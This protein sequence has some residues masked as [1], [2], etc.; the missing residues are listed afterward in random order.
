MLKIFISFSHILISFKLTLHVYF[1][2]YLHVPQVALIFPSIP[3]ND[4]SHWMV[5]KNY[6]HIDGVSTP[7]NGVEPGRLHSFS[8]LVG[9]ALTNQQ[10]DYCGN[11]TVFP[12]SH[13]KVSEKLYDQ[14]N[15]QVINL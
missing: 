3:S 6:A 14:W 4:P 8:L 7:T 5:S 2:P 9:I 10:D 1:K 13:C 15:H 11:L 12:G